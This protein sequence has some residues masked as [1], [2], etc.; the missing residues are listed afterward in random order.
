MWYC[1]VF[2]NDTICDFPSASSFETDGFGKK[3]KRRKNHLLFPF[4]Q[5]HR[6]YSESGNG[7]YQRV[8]RIEI[9][10]KEWELFFLNIKS[11]MGL[12]NGVVR[13]E[14]SVF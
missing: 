6:Q 1:T 11:D 5:P 10:I 3:Q 7:T 14:T 2:G 8:K 12:K 13:N 4:G 9:T